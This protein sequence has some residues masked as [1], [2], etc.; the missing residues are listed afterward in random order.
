[1]RG[2]EIKEE[3]RGKE[4]NEGKENGMDEADGK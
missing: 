2:L 1:M 4:E 3:R